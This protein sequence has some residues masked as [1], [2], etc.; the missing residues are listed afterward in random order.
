MNVLIT[1]GAGFIGTYVRDL[2]HK[3]GHTLYILDNLSTGNEMNINQEDVFLKGDLLDRHSLKMLEPYQI[4]I[5]IH[6]AAQISVP[7]S[8]ENPIEDMKVN[9]E[10]TLNLLEFA[11][12]NGVKKFIFA[13]SAAVYGN[14][15]NVP[16][17]EEQELN[18]DSPYG[19]SKMAGEHYVKTLCQEN[20]IDYVILRFANVFGPKQSEEGEGGVIKIFADQL[21][22]NE[23]PFIYG[24]GDQTRDFIYVED[25]A[26]ALT[27][28]IAAES[29]IYNLSTNTETNINEVFRMISTAMNLPAVT[30]KYLPARKGD[31]YRSS[32]ENQKFIDATGWNPIYTVKNA[33]EKMIGEMRE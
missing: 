30:P 17:R 24:D 13:S 7:L 31:I 8:V 18:P 2:F 21:T 33:I 19:I 29:G 23:S 14:T 25:V 6:L 15:V 11:K 10:G 1:G 22:K 26:R 28:S 4:D 12:N 27:Y 3:E 9:I 32:L 5:I 20:M 16:I